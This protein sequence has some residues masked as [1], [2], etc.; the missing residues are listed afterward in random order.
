MNGGGRFVEWLVVRIDDG[1]LIEWIAAVNGGR[2]FW[3]I[4]GTY[5]YNK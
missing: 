5:C 3:Q 1:K 2:K 4:D